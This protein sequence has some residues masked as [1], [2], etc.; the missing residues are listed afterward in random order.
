MKSTRVSACVFVVAASLAGCG[1]TGEVEYAGSVRVTSPEL[2]T[3]SPGVQVVADAEEP[4]FYSHNNYWLYRD[5]YWFR[6]DNYRNGFARVDFVY[7][8]GELRVIDRPQLYVQYKRHI[9]RDRFARPPQQQT[10]TLEPQPTPS[11]TPTYPSTSPTEPV[12]PPNQPAVPGQTPGGVNPTTYPPAHDDRDRH[13]DVPPMN[14]TDRD[15]DR[16]RDNG[17]GVRPDDRDD[18]GERQK[19]DRDDRGTPPT[20]KPDKDKKDKKKDKY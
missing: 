4:L 5:G 3:V 14:H 8:P 10:R 19:S 15:A 2:I 6:S 17:T 1:A 13:P 16:D 18:R 12:Q 11:Q 7:V 20:E 9:G